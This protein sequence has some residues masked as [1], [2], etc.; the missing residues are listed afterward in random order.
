MASPPRVV[1]RFIV[2]VTGAT[3]RAQRRVPWN[4][5]GNE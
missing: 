4:I 3:I 1:L 2:H 5:N